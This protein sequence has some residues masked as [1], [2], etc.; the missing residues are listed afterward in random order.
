MDNI[1]H[2]LG[3][4]LLSRAGLNRLSPRATW[5]LVAAANVP[6][7]DMLAT[8]AGPGIA[9]RTH[10]GPLHSLVA[11]PLVAL[12]VTMAIWLVRRKDFAWGRAYAVALA[13]AASNPIFDLANA[14]GVRI[15]WPFSGRW[16]HADFLP[17]IDPWIWLL[18]LVGLVAPW[19]SRL[20]SS[21]MGAK[22]GSGRGAAILVLSLISA[23]CFGR[24]LLHERAVAVLDSHMY[25]GE[26][27]VRVAA[28]PD[29]ASPFRWT[30]LVEGEGFIEELPEVNLLEDFNPTAGVVYYKPPP[31]PEVARARETALFRAFLD[32]AQWPVW[33]VAP[34]TGPE[35]GVTVE[36]TDLR[37]GAPGHSR[38][39]VTAR[40]DGSGR[41]VETKPLF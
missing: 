23:Y 26:I 36:L 31:G 40:L 19:L 10:R 32:F 12:L 33:R 22:P 5:L 7:L 30:G 16:F 27:A 14:Y 1:T 6:D 20:V 18:L 38:F 4:I 13:G 39:G 34:L 17:I 3:A 37:F 2:T 9:I 35:G 11:L 41:V 29:L 21:E 8:L 15:L 28:L 25:Q 24:Y